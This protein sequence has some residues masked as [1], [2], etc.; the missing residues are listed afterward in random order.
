MNRSIWVEY[1]RATCESIESRPD[2]LREGVHAA[3]SAVL[4]VP[5]RSF[6]RVRI[7]PGG[8]D[9]PSTRMHRGMGVPEREE[10]VPG[11]PGFEIQGDQKQWKSGGVDLD[12]AGP[13][14]GVFCGLD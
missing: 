1:C 10:G 11:S 13:F 5:D 3:P 9:G 7:G 8:S 14:A 2:P 6:H 4:F 12:R